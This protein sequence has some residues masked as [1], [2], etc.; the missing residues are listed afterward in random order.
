MAT[1]LDDLPYANGMRF[2]P[3]RVCYRFT[4]KEILETIFDWANASDAQEQIL[5]LTGLAGSGKSAIAHTIA[6]R[7]YALHRLGSSFF[8][9]LSKHENSRPE[10]I[11]STVARDIADLEPEFKVKLW[12]AIKDNRSL[13]KTESPQEQY[14]SF[15]C[16][17]MKGLTMVGPVL[18]VIDA[19]DECGDTDRFDEL[20]EVLSM[21][22]SELPP[23][24]RIL[25]TTRDGETDIEKAF[26]A[27]PL[28]RHMRMADIES[29]STDIDITAF[30]HNKL[31]G[32]IPALEVDWPRG[33]WCSELVCKA[34]GL[35][36]FASTACLFIIGKGKVDISPS[37]RLKQVLSSASAAFG[38]LDG[39]YLQVLKHAVAE[40]GM[41]KFKSLMGRILTAVRPLS[42]TALNDLREEGEDVVTTTL[43]QP[44]GSLL[45]GTTH[46][47]TPLQPL[48]ATFAEFIVKSD[49]SMTFHID[50]EQ[51][52]RSLTRSCFRVMDRGL[53]RDLCDFGDVFIQYS[54]IDDLRSR[55][56]IPEA[57][58]YACRSWIP[59]LHNVKNDIFLPLFPLI[60]RILH[61]HLLHWIEAWSLMQQLDSAVMLLRSLMEW[62]EVCHF[63][64]S[65]TRTK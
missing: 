26:Y 20:V 63:F 56:K 35:F 18:I 23:N 42:I 55:T 33:S 13:R 40:T 60:H 41:T 38:I 64:F 12:D 22:I 24:F 50:A 51:A 15:I 21:R 43:L 30:V 61:V 8:C 6:Q 1:D 46:P 3:T 36:I 4:R 16:G 2:D 17:P 31:S 10:K 54:D 53:K 29:T 7:F 62:L 32:I 39:L 44:L 5:L 34:H 25:L 27:N 45:S 47:N 14:D 11:F 59:H 52:E 37:E 48:H 58:E 57:L 28:V 9:S 49:R 65:R 19:L